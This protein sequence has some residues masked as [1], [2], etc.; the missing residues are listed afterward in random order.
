MF[1]LIE[2]H[3]L[4]NRLFRL[5]GLNQMGVMTQ[6]LDDAT[7]R[8]SRYLL[9]QFAVNTCSAVLCGTGLYL[10]GVPYAALWGSV[11]GL[12]RIVPYVGAVCLHCSPLRS[13]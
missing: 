8:V 6:A 10:I 5:V 3:D 12:L 13:R 11:A 2:E 4:R 1:L 9:I 7:R